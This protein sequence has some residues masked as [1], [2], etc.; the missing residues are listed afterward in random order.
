MVHLQRSASRLPGPL[1]CEAIDCASQVVVWASKATVNVKAEPGTALL[2]LKS[3]SELE[4]HSHIRCKQSI[5]EDFS[6]LWGI[7]TCYKRSGTGARTKSRITFCRQSPNGGD[8]NVTATPPT[9]HFPTSRTALDPVKAPPPRHLARSRTLGRC[10]SCCYN[11]CPRTPLISP[12]TYHSLTP[13]VLTN[14]CSPLLLN[15]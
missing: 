6:R 9:F 1:M 14:P 13:Y 8:Q 4:Y 11:A 2:A 5:C 10:R 3:T 12:L 15:V 7:Y